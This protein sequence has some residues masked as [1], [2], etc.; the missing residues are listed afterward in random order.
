MSVSVA[1]QSCAK[2]PPSQP[3]ERWHAIG[4]VNQVPLVVHTFREEGLDAI[5]SARK[6]TTGE[7]KLHE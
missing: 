3:R 5:I 6:A 2:S 7:R 1:R 4:Y